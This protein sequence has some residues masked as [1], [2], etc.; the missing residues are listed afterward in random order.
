MEHK[1]KSSRK[2]GRGLLWSVA[3]IAVIAAAGVVGGKVMLEKTVKTS[4]ENSGASA[5]SVKV[6]YNGRVTLSDVTIPLENDHAMHIA[7]VEARPAFLFVSGMVDAQDIE[8]DAG[9]AVVT[10]PSVK[11]EDAALNRAFLAAVTG[12]NE[13]TMA[14]RAEHLSA[15]HIEVSKIDVVQ[16]LEGVK[17]TTTYSDVVLNDIVAGQ[18]GSYSASGMETRMNMALFDADADAESVPE[19]L[20]TVSMGAVEGQDID[21]PFIV[22]VYTEAKPADGDNAPQMAYGPLSVKDF[23]MDVE[24]EARVTY[25]EM[26][27]DGFSMRLADTPL[28]DLVEAIQAV[29]ERGSPTPEE[30]QELGLDALSVAGVIAKGDIQISGIGMTTAAQ[31]DLDFAID[32][33]SMTIDDMVLGFSLDGLDISSGDDSITLGSASWT[34]LSLTPTLDELRKF[35]EAGPEGAGN[36][37]GTAFLPDL[38]TF[39]M[40]DYAVNLNPT[41]DE[42]SGFDV[43]EPV[44]FTMKDTTIVMRAPFNGIPTDI[45]FSI[46]GLNLN[47]ADNEDSPAVETLKKL[48]YEDVTLSQNIQAHWDRDNNALIIDDISFS[49]VD[50]ASIALSGT[51][52]GF[53]EEFFS[54]DKF[55]MQAALFGLTAHEVKLRLE[56]SGLFA[57]ALKFYADENDMSEE[58]AKMALAMLPSIAAAT[59]AD[60][61]P[62]VQA[63]I[64]AVSAFVANPNTLE[65]SVKAKSEE[66]I[67][68]PALIGAA[69]DPESLLSEVDITATAE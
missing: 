13:L 21:I 30:V 44:N 29:S 34:D 43:D 47:I 49:G 36:F 7:A 40:T 64:E 41:D 37:T 48:G 10:V 35:L 54:G 11:I 66:G 68:A 59:V 18:V 19:D 55:T 50:M 52:G 69:M 14:E 16:S 9:E 51:L 22:K 20:M 67:G 25:E 12:E 60:D 26:S 56:N 33:L 32:K 2:A 1:E 31:P 8:I 15:G 57:R 61:D 42:E 6:G 27:S 46:D 38:G 58:Q 5:A 4:L 45:R 23:V 39:K 65:V 3:A 63:V 17:Q 62:G 53:G 24:G 28:L